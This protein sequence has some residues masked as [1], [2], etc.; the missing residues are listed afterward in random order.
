[1]VLVI[2]RL[3]SEKMIRSQC[4]VY[5][6]KHLKVL[7]WTSEWNLL[8]LTFGLGPGCAQHA[9][10]EWSDS[11][12]EGGDPDPRTGKKGEKSHG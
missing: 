2:S 10:V 4:V 8:S 12:V 6:V 3:C 1:V 9:S 7:D 11:V 5:F